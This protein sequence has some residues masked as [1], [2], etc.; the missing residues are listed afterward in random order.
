MKD[1]HII[2]ADLSKD[3][4]DLASHQLK[5]YVQIDNCKK[6]F[7]QMLRW[8]KKQNIRTELALIVMEHTGVYSFA[9]ESFLLKH[10]IGF[11][12]VPALAIKRSLGMVR[13]KN[14]KIDAQRIARYGF[15]KKEALIPMEKPDPSIA[16][17]QH[18]QN[19]RDF[20][21]KQRSALQCRVQSYRILYPSGD[22]II[23]MQRKEI[24]ELNK[25]IKLL[26]EKINELVNSNPLIDKNFRMLKTVR[27]VGPVVAAATIIKT[28]NFTRI[29]DGRKF[30]CFCGTAP[31]EHKS[32]KS[33]RRRTRVS[34]LADKGM[35]TLL[36]MSARTAIQHDPEL[37]AFYQRRIE[38]GKSKQSTI[39]IVRNK[40]IH[41][42]FAVIKR[43]TS[44]VDNYTRTA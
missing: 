44:F 34:H 14:D 38:G 42:M 30:S 25:K 40:I 5:S 9:L 26:D 18:L 29:T 12:K 11:V 33:I 15:E 43:Q 24:N 37:K 35:K 13:G 10:N 28:H 19:T 16:R 17:L 23:D 31:F 6:G 20:F 27:G 39:N 32:G 2:G 7:S 22:F 41:R 21:V 4:I 1:S 36:E 3:T 8:F